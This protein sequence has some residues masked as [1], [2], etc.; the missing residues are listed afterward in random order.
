MYQ[1]PVLFSQNYKIK[2]KVSAV[3]V[4]QSTTE[5]FAHIFLKTVDCGVIP[6]QILK[7]LA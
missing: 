3:F 6:G 5:L 2:C 7:D 1:Y 4:I